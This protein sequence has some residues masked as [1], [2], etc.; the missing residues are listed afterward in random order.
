MII[1]P[2]GPT[3][4]IV[5]TVV[6]PGWTIG[7]GSGVT[8]M[9]PERP[10]ARFSTVIRGGVSPGAEANVCSFDG[11]LCGRLRIGGTV[12][13]RATVNELWRGALP[14]IRIVTETRSPSANG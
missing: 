12:P 14:W 6:D 3:A 10:G 4:L 9:S 8:K 11:C 7:D 13:R 1:G 2:P 5:S